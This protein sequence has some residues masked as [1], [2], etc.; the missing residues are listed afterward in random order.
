[1]L[2]LLWGEQKRNM[3]VTFFNS[4]YINSIQQKKGECYVCY[5]G[6]RGLIMSTFAPCLSALK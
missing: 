5:G 1:M 2:R 6:P 3:R 4:L